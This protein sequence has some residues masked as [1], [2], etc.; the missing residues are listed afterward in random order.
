MRDFE[1]ELHMSIP[2]RFAA[3]DRL[4]LGLVAAMA[5]SGCAQDRFE[6]APADYS[7]AHLYQVYCS[8]CHGWDGHGSGSVEPYTT[9]R[10]PDLTQISARNGGAFPSE[11]VFRTI[12][13][14]FDSPPPD[15]RHMPIWGYDFF[16]GEGDDE[17]A[18]QRVL[19]MEHR[20]VAYVESLQEAA[21]G[22]A[23]LQH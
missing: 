22:T 9:A 21:P 1:L 16:N 18:H 2:S 5:L 12:D 8:G 10:A 11:R 4:V 3:V 13:G 6:D 20:V 23:A 17:T 14:Q 15:A 19:D 7:G